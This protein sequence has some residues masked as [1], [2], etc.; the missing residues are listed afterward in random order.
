MI[1]NIEG[2][3]EL[4]LYFKNWYFKPLFEGELMMVTEACTHLLEVVAERCSCLRLSHNG[5][6]IQVWMP[7]HV[8]LVE[9]EATKWRSRPQPNK[10]PFKALR[11]RLS[12]GSSRSRSSHVA[13]TYPH[14]SYALR[15]LI[16]Q[17]N[18]F[19]LPPF[20]GC[21]FEILNTA[22]LTRL[23]LIDVKLSS[24]VSA[25]IFWALTIP[26]LEHLRIISCQFEFDALA[27]FLS[28]HNTIS[29]FDIISPWDM[30]KLPK[31]TL[32]ALVSLKSNPNNV[33]R[34][35]TPTGVFPKL[36]HVCVAIHFFSDE[37]FTFDDVEDS[38]ARA[39]K[40][41]TETNIR[42]CLDVLTASHTDNF[43]DLMTLPNDL[44][45]YPVLSQ[46]REVA[47]GFPC[48]DVVATNAISTWLS[49]FPLLDHVEFLNTQVGLDHQTEMLLLRRI[50]QKCSRLHSVRIGEETHDV[51]AWLS[52]DNC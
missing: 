51:S 25:L 22:P 47:F 1:V 38:L 29:T 2:L 19:L 52:S 20:S 49:V 3:E 28:R 45:N 4:A 32:P 13:E 43:V 46:V 8:E 15:T 35:L 11:R 30:H 50:V 42:L 36:A 17:S 9:K 23:D 37:L 24:R 27:E 21:A 33:D 39:A 10:G 18:M 5:N 34:L 48:P 14:R 12:L 26:T 31:T 6:S 41:L 16:F 44:R 7:F 40:R